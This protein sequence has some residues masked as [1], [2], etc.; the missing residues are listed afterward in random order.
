MGAAGNQPPLKL[1]ENCFPA[2]EYKLVLTP[3]F[4]WEDPEQLFILTVARS[5]LRSIYWSIDLEK[6]KRRFPPEI[7]VFLE[8]LCWN[9]YSFNQ[10]NQENKE[11]RFTFIIGLLGP[12]MDHLLHPKWCTQIHTRVQTLHLLIMTHISV[13]QSMKF[14]HYCHP[15]VLTRAT[16]SCRRWHEPY[17]PRHEGSR[18]KFKRFREMLWAFHMS[19]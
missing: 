4:V 16:R 3:G 5:D 6:R 10:M 8:H 13:N 14:I 1:T 18:E 7:F 9:I 11:R 19:M 2:A 17:Q 12:L 15:F